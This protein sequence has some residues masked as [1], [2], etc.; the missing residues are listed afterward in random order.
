MKKKI[1]LEELELQ[2]G[3]LCDGIPVSV[4]IGATCTILARAG[5]AGGIEYDALIRH[6]CD[7]VAALYLANGGI[8]RVIP[9]E[10][11]PLH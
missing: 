3:E 5:V 1:E 10:G 8:M 7:R 11:E 9:E 2:M 4:C 6:M